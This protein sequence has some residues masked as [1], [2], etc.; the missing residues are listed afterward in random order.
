MG[1]RI[2]ITNRQVES[3]Y[4]T[5]LKLDGSDGLAFGHNSINLL[6]SLDYTLGYI[7]RYVKYVSNKLFKKKK[8][9]TTTT[10][11]NTLG[12]ISLFLWGKI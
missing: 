2:V 3:A 10:S 9:A 5:V 11:E 8:T 6:K 1:L 7:L 12:K 4:E